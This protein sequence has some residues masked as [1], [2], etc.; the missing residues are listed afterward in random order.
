MIYQNCRE[1]P[2]HWF[3]EIGLTGDLK[4]LIKDGEHTEEELNDAWLDIL[5]EYVLIH[6]IGFLKQEQQEKQKLAYM[7]QRMAIIKTVMD[8]DVYSDELLKKLKLTRKTIKKE[9]NKLRQKTAQLHARLN[10][11]EEIKQ[12]QSGFEKTVIQLSKYYGFKIDRYTTTVSEW[13][14][15]IGEVKDGRKD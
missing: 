10:T 11:K 4:Y 12:E 13:L 8:F 3:N 6:P 5:S 9:Y 15:F 2:I 7:S 1:L 14:Q